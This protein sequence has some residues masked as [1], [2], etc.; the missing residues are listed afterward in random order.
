MYGD[1]SEAMEQLQGADDAVN[2][3]EDCAI[4]Q[5]EGAGEEVDWETRDR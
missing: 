2:G 1:G 5:D 4:V 3:G